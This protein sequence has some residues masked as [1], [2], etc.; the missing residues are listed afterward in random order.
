MDDDHAKK[1]AWEGLDL[2]SGALEPDRSGSA[3]LDQAPFDVLPLFPCHGVPRRLQA[4]T[5]EERDLCLRYR[6]VALPGNP[7]AMRF[8]AVT[9]AALEAARRFGLRVIARIDP[10]AFADAFAEVLA[11]AVLDDAV[12]GLAR[13]H[14]ELS[15]CRRF[16]LRQHIAALYLALALVVALRFADGTRIVLTLA[17]LAAFFF[18]MMVSIRI[19]AL[20]SGRTHTYARV[21]RLAVAD[22]PVY[23][24]LVPLFRETAVL[25]QLITGLR[26]LRYP[27]LCIKRTKR[28]P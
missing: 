26:A 22:L 15:A 5:P 12:H 13:A 28:L 17:I 3:N 9:P 8:A 14:P 16:T 21:P 20:A 1:G 23:T 11:P 4:L 2:T 7:A 18:G 27:A 19:L 6:L 10:T 25:A 24:V